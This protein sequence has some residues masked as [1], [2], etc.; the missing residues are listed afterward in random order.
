MLGH[1]WEGLAIEMARQQQT[2]SCWKAAGL[3]LYR[4]PGVDLDCLHRRTCSVVHAVRIFGG[5][6][7]EVDCYA[8][9]GY[10]RPSA[11]RPQ[12]DV[13]ESSDRNMLMV[14]RLAG[15]GKMNTSFATTF[16]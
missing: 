10:Y 14:L 11:V 2:R 15:K 1:R 7:D 8:T 12:Q 4:Q 5:F 13:L 3:P 16:R 9:C 6:K